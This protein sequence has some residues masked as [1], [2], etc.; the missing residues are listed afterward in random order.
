MV[1]SLAS[2]LL[3]LMVLSFANETMLKAAS[4]RHDAALLLDQ[5]RRYAEST[6]R[7]L[8]MTNEAFAL[9]QYEAVEEAA[10][11]LQQAATILEDL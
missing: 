7:A 4:M 5:A 11:I 9:D 1:I 3:A 6:E 2:L 10:E 8:V